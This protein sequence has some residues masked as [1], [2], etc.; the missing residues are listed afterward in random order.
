MKEWFLQRRLM[1]LMVGIGVPLLGALSFW[2]VIRQNWQFWLACYVVGFPAALFV[3]WVR[4]HGREYWDSLGTR[5]RMLLR[6]A[7]IAIL[8]FLL[9]LENHD[10]FLATVITVG[11]VL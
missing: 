7:V 4:Q 8:W 5:K 2:S 6:C 11:V 3:T 10:R 9:V 1:L